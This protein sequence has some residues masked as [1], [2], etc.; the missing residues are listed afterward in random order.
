MGPVH[1]ATGLGEEVQ[2]FDISTPMNGLRQ[3]VRPSRPVPEPFTPWDGAF[4]SL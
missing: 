4:T 1:V 3:E 2:P